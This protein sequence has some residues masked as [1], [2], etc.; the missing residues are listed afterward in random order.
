M[1]WLRALRKIIKGLIPNEIRLKK[2]KVGFNT[3]I[4]DVIDF[5]NKKNINFT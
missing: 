3:S 4:S 2:E 5:K 1:V